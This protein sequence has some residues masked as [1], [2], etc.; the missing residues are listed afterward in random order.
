MEEDL[1]S[2]KWHVALWV[3]VIATDV[4]NAEKE[5]WAVIEKADNLDDIKTECAQYTVT[6]IETVP[7]DSN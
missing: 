5:V 1:M 7:D 6:N 4:A 3:E 2:V